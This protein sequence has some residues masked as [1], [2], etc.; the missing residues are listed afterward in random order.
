MKVAITGASGLLGSALV[1]ALRAGGH[2]VVRFVRRTPRS[3]DEAPWDPAR[4]ELDPA[5]LAE[6]NAVIHLA[7]VGI[8][9]RPWTRSYRRAIYESRV[10][11]T[12]TVARAVAAQPSPPMLLS[13]SAVGWYG[14]TGGRLVDETGPPGTGF[15]A[16]VCHEWEKAADP[17]RDAGA[18]VLHLR[19][20]PVLA[21]HGGMLGPLL[22]LFRLGLGGRLGSGRQYLS[23]ISLRD[24]LAAVQSLL[25]TDDV[26][27]PVNLCSPQPVTNAEFTAALGAA[28]HRP[29]LL[30]VP[31]PLVRLALGATAAANLLA[32][33]RVTPAVLTRHGFAFADNDLPSALQWV[34]AE[35]RGAAKTH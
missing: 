33:Q 2:T 11:G 17:A 18:R 28:L 10:K 14:E 25:I 30:P 19:T 21:P 16:R 8:G 4:G 12:M 31:A 35:H 6:V 26:A 13:A 1:P 29:T 7:G 15:L 9:A 3:G 20:A 22:P 32:G 27:G 34:L 23:W 5:H 24:H